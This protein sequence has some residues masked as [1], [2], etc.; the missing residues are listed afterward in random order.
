MDNNTN[1]IN[2]E[3]MYN[4]KQTKYK[5]LT[6]KLKKSKHKI[7]KL[8]VQRKDA[9]GR[10]E[11]TIN[12]KIAKCKKG[13]NKRKRKIRKLEQKLHTMEMDLQKQQWVNENLEKQVAIEKRIAYL[14][15]QIKV[16]SLLLKEAVPGLVAKYGRTSK[17]SENRGAVIDAPWYKEIDISE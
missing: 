2:W 3:N 11:E 16:S 15:N 17:I 12:K 4:D 14:E 9:Y 5:K 13:Q 8:K 1:V 7:K 6:K 10:E